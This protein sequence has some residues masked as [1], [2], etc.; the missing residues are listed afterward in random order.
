MTGMIEMIARRTLAWLLAAALAASPAAGQYS[1]ARPLSEQ[2][3]FPIGTTGLVT[4]TAQSSATDRALVD[5]FDRGYA[6]VCRDAATSVGQVYALRVRGGD[7]V[8]RLAALRA[9]RATCEAS[10]PDRIEGLGAIEAAT[11]RLA[12]ADVGYRVYVHRAGDTVYV[13]EGLAGYDGALRLALRSVVADRVVPGE[14]GIALTG[15]GDPVAFARVQAG[16][17]DRRRALAEAYRRNNAGN[18]AES[19]EYFAVLT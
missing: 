1:D 7:P 12:G 11:C 14:V 8:G 15:A 3:G 4:C 6:I 2:D 9:G 5:M 18:F 13:A 17:L 19:A 10:A 16:A